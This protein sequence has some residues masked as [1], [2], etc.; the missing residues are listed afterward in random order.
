[1]PPIVAAKFTVLPNKDLSTVA[2]LDREENSQY[3]FFITVKDCSTP[4]LTDR[5]R[6]TITVSDVND[7]YPIFPGPYD[8]SIK[9][10][11]SSGSR[12]VQV[13]ATGKYWVM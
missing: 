6:V 7:N 2:A 4:P 9:E 8:V 11:E 1:M 13:K 5:V 3:V 10:G 12:V